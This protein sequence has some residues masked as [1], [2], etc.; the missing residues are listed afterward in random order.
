ME[1]VG[2]ARSRSTEHPVLVDEPATATV[3][4]MNEGALG[5]TLPGSSEI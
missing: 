2:V 5:A 3:G 4:R 1:Q